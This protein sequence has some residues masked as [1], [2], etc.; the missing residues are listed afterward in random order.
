VVKKRAGQG[1]RSA[2][3]QDLSPIGCVDHVTEGC[4]HSVIVHLQETQGNSC[5]HR[6]AIFKTDSRSRSAIQESLH[7]CPSHH[8]SFRLR[9]SQIVFTTCSVL[10]VSLRS[11]D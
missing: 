2:R 10:F 9:F 11:D 4:V 8:R 3:R 7:P 5:N 1:N 6:A